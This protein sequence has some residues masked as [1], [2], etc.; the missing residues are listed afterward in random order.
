MQ[1]KLYIGNL[2]YQTTEDDLQQHFS[3][4]GEIARVQLIKDR[5]TGQSKGFAFVE[6]ASEDGAEKALQEDG[7]DF[8]GRKIRVSEARPQEKRDFRGGDRGG[9]RSR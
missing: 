3:Q 1:K 4:F 6:M 5:D 8:M 2:S 9:P 7:T